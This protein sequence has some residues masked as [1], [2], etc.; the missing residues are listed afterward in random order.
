MGVGNWLSDSTG[1]RGRDNLLLSA[2]VLIGVSIVGT[3]LSLFIRRLPIANPQL[4][5]SY[6]A[7]GRCKATQ[8]E[9]PPSHQQTPVQ[10][11]SQPARSAVPSDLCAGVLRGHPSAEY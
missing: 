4:P 8:M 3:L 6:G 9:S 7:L 1:F 10:L 2:T 11:C 5:R